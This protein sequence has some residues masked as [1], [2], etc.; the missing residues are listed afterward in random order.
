MPEAFGIRYKEGRMVFPCGNTTKI[1]VLIPLRRFTGAS[2][3][4]PS[5]SIAERA[6]LKREIDAAVPAQ[7]DHEDERVIS[8]AEELEDDF[9]DDDSW[10]IGK[11]R[12]EF[13]RRRRG[14]ARR[15]AEEDPVQVCRMHF[16]PIVSADYLHLHFS[17]QGTGGTPTMSGTVTLDR[18]TTLMR[19]CGADTG[20]KRLRTSLRRR[21]CLWVCVWP[22]PS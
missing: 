13:H 9:R 15:E 2:T 5:V 14:E 7:P 6:S 10:Y 17:G 12:E 16:G 22:L 21:C 20:A 3:D 11:A 18:K 1:N 8:T 4:K 19:R